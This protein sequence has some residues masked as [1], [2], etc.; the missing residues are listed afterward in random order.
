MAQRGTNL[1]PIAV[2]VV[3]VL[4][5]ALLVGLATAGLVASAGATGTAPAG[6]F[7]W[8][9]VGRPNELSPAVAQPCMTD[10][11]ATSEG[12][13]MAVLVPGDDPTDCGS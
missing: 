7:D 2:I 10:L 1:R 4:V 11:L 5:G 13:Q 9:M 12:M 8:L 6:L 3:L